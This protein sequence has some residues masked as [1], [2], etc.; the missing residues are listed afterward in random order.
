M[1]EEKKKAVGEN[2]LKRKASPSSPLSPPSSPTP[3]SA[4][5]CSGGASTTPQFSFSKEVNV[6]DDVI[7][8]TLD[9]CFENSDHIL[10]KVEAR[11]VF[12]KKINSDC[13]YYSRVKIFD[14]SYDYRYNQ[15]KH[16]YLLPLELEV[17]DFRKLTCLYYS[18]LQGTIMDPSVTRLACK[19]LAVGNVDLRLYSLCVFLASISTRRTFNDNFVFPSCVGRSSTGKS[20]MLH[21]FT[22]CAKIVSFDSQGVSRYELKEH[23]TSYYFHDFDLENIFSKSNLQAVKC[24]MRGERITVKTN[25]ATQELMPAFCFLTA[26]QA[27]FQHRDA[28]GRILNDSTRFPVHKLRKAD[29]EAVQYRL[30]EIYY[31]KPGPKVHLSVFDY[32]ISME[33]ARTALSILILQEMDKL[34]DQHPLRVGSP[35]L[36]PSVFRGMTI[37]AEDMARV[38][39]VSEQA[40]VSKIQQYQVLYK[41]KEKAKAS[42][43]ISIPSFSL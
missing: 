36:F 8:E 6:V 42:E 40:I 2:R 7:R 12:H 31:A 27:L 25:G 14:A 39:G 37:A 19:S 21:S 20:K 13:V 3:S 24:I 28:Y 38:L 32:D 11:K 41:E 4:S 43:D 33:Q 34:K 1:M 16:Q 10:G 9:Q 23:Q 29:L 15:I 18:L 17:P 5:S 22:S 35:V 26:N 30:L